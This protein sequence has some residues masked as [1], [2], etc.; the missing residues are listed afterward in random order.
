MSSLFEKSA[1]DTAKAM[2]ASKDAI[3]LKA[4]QT[5]EPMLKVL[6]IATRGRTKVYPDK[7]EVF[8][9]DDE[10][11]IEF[12]PVESSFVDGVIKF[13]QRYKEF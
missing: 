3:L 10:P 12:W 11:V 1:Q 4:L 9:W 2:V 6:E 8:F 13:T 7:T 5:K